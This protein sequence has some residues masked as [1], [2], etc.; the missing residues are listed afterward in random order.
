MDKFS[1]ALHPVLMKIGSSRLR[2]LLPGAFLFV[3]AWSASAQTDPLAGAPAAP[4]PAKALPVYDHIVIV[5]EENKDYEQIVNNEWTP[6]ISSVLCKEGAVFTRMYAE[7]HHSEG[8]YFWLLSGS[9]Q[10]VAFLDKMPRHS[11]DTPN[12]PE[13]LI[14]KGLSFTGYA[15]DLPAIGSDVTFYPAKPARPLYARKHVP[16]V[17]FSNIPA[18]DSVPFSEFPEDPAKFSALPTLAIVIPNLINDMHDGKPAE[19][20]PLGDAWLRDHLDAYYQWAKSHNSLLLVTFDEN[21][22]RAGYSGLTNPNVVPGDG[23]DQEFRRDVQNRIPTIMAGA[24]IKPGEYAEG[25]GITHVNLLRTL[26]AMYGLDKTGAQQQNAAGFGIA[27]D[28]I[29]TDVFD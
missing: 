18:S 19:S 12:L 8:N 21:D 20:V 29:V 5:F 3:F 17:S 4:A 13:Q 22:D 26:E 10:N 25:Q 2:A 27:D 28:Y 16:W 11:L 15:E 7:E 6:Y 1:K 9:N 14:R 24:H 23:P